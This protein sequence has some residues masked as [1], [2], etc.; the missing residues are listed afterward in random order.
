VTAIAPA[1]DAV[2]AARRQVS[3]RT[4]YAVVGLLAL[5]VVA[6]IV[7]ITQGDFLIS[8]PD[9]LRIVR[10]AEIPGASYILMESKLPRAV[11]GTGVGAALGLAG[12]I[13][14]TTL[15]N[16]LASPDIVGVT[17]GASAAAVFGIVILGQDGPVIS[18][19]AVAGALGVALLV[20]AL[21]QG[22][23]GYR[24]V[25][26]G[27][28]ISAVM[29]AVIQYLFTRVDEF[30]ATKVLQWLGGSL[31]NVEW[32]SIGLFYALVLPVLAAIAW[33]SRVLRVAE[34]GDDLRAGLGAGSGSI[35]LLMALAVILA[36]L[37]TAV[38][39]PVAFVAFLSGPISRALTGGRTRLVPAALV[40]AVL[41]VLGD[42]IGAYLL[43]DVNL[44][45]GIITGALGAPALIWLIA[46]GAT[47]RGSR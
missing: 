43:G 14:Q 39:G 30:N 46:T 32:R 31:S 27:I 35:D 38:A 12:A 9:T 23:N 13:F 26:L 8:L 6:F 10:G 24:L 18:A 37:A 47:T 41:V 11:L 33:Q 20:R 45:V 19:L 4:A 5:W 1:I 42:H 28:G 44:P 40:G 21:A 7:R 25:L 29:Q 34:L 3:R 16:E 2:Q 15:R 22:Q 36:G 17:L